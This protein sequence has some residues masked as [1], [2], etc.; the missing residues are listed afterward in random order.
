MHWDN[1]YKRNKNI[2]GD[3]P[4]ELTKTSIEFLEKGRFRKKEKG[5]WVD[6]S[7]LLEALDI[8]CGYGRDSFYLYENLN[9]IL[10]GIDKSPEAIRIALSNKKVGEENINFK[11]I[12][13]RDFREGSFDISFASNLYQLLKKDERDEFRKTLGTI[14][15]PNGVLFLSTLS[16]N[17][18]EHSNKGKVCAN[19]PNSYTGNV[20]LHMCTKEELLDDFS[21]LKIEEL[22]EHEYFEP[23]STGETHHHISWILIGRKDG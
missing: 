20:F 9:C 7:E 8:G 4:S 3:S 5:D 17:D 2:W 16:V 22:Y 15:K 10:L 23:R 14:M 18:P 12:D 19:D 1:E 13:F 21:F 11:C 6:T